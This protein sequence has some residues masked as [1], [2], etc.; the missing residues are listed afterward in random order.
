[1]IWGLMGSIGVT[2][3]VVNSCNCSCSFY[4]KRVK[5]GKLAWPGIACHSTLQLSIPVQAFC[6][7][8]YYIYGGIQ[9]S[10]STFVWMSWFWFYATNQL[11]KPCNKYLNKHANSAKSACIIKPIT[12]KPRILKKK[13]PSFWKQHHILKCT[14]RLSSLLY[15]I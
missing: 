1:M 6:C 15:L 7:I 8:H 5:T 13:K 14:W 4:L 10:V 2:V 9:A 3:A 12:I 11:N